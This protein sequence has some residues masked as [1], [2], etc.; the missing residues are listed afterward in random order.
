MLSC[1]G[2]FW[3]KTTSRPRNILGV[4][5]YWFL[6]KNSHLPLIVHVLDYE[7]GKT[8][9]LAA[10]NV[11]GENAMTTT[12]EEASDFIQT[13]NAVNKMVTVYQSKPLA[14]WCEAIEGVHSGGLCYAIWTSTSD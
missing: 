13:A 1:A 12:S 2:R 6:T 3:L 4:I 14:S 8:A 7:Y 5:G 10:K 9:L 11:A